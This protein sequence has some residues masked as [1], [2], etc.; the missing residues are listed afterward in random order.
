MVA[1]RVDRDPRLTIA[2]LLAVA[3]AGWA[4]MS[5]HPTHGSG[6]ATVFLMWNVMMVAMMLPS[7]LPWLYLFEGER[8]TSFVAGYLTIWVVYCALATIAQV[9]LGVGVRATPTLSGALLI[10]AGAFQL[11]PLK[12][13]CLRACRSPIG[14]LLSR[15]RSDRM[16]AFRTGLAHGVHCL[17]CCW[18]LMALAFVLGVMNL[19]WMAVLTLVMSVEKLAPSGVTASRAIGVALLVSGVSVLLVS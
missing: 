2:T 17:G 10:G 6:P 13:A 15:W 1:V 4:A 7:L 11:T 8:V 12:A 9:Y 5:T 14:L 19:W 3:A 18:A 16:W